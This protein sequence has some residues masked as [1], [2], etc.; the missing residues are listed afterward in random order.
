MKAV[1]ATY[2]FGDGNDGMIDE[3]M[4]ACM[5]PIEQEVKYI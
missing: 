5:K 4:A 3:A 2:S 1:S